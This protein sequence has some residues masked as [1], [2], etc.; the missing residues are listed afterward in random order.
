MVSKFALRRAF[1][2]A[3]RIRVGQSNLG[4]SLLGP[5]L[6]GADAPLHDAAVRGGGAVSTG[7]TAAEEGGAGTHTKRSRETPCATASIQLIQL[8]VPRMVDKCT[9][10]NGTRSNSFV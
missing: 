3:A 9:G 4:V 10:R 5:C 7:S 2:A 1:I 8:Q 6:F